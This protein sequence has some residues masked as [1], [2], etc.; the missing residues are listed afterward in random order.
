MVIWT[1]KEDE[2]ILLEILFLRKLSFQQ[3][4]V[5]MWNTQ[6]LN[7]SSIFLVNVSF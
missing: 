6:L 3:A 4:K 7:A 5:N 2:T 1:E